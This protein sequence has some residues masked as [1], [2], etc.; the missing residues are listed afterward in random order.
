M[1]FE[2]QTVFKLFIF[3]IFLSASNGLVAQTTDTKAL[4]LNINFTKVFK[5]DEFHIGQ[6]APVFLLTD[7]KNNIHEIELNIF[8][9]DAYQSSSLLSGTTYY[10]DNKE[11]SAGLRYQFDLN[12]VKKGKLIPFIGVSALTLFQ[13]TN[14]KPLST[15]SYPRRTQQLTE[16]LSIIPQIRFS[17]WPRVFVDLA[18]PIDL[19]DVSLVTQR[20][21]NPYIPIRQQRNSGIE[22]SLPIKENNIFHLR[23]GLGVKL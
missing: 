1:P 21:S 16:L 18:I 22:T 14:V 3:L 2:K 19:F 12:L 10:Y 15:T 20:I 17:L 7:K 13:S 23:L 11:T 4:K 8:N 9:V 5:E 6:L